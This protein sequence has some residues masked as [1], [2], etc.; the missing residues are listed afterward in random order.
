MFFV[1]AFRFSFPFAFVAIESISSGDRAGL[2]IHDRGRTLVIALLRMI[3][4]G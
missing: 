4:R 1:F 3:V 2:L